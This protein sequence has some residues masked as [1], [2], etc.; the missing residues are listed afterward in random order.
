M[1]LVHKSFG[2]DSRVVG[3]SMIVGRMIFSIV[4]G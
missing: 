4:G 1:V 2:G 3:S